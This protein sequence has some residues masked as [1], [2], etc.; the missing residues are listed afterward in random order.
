MLQ[1][2][3]QLMRVML[4]Y[5]EVRKS[6]QKL[7]YCVWFIQGFRLLAFRFSCFYPLCN[8]ISD[9]TL[10]LSE[11]GRLVLC[12]GVEVNTVT[13]ISAVDVANLHLGLL[14]W[15]LDHTHTSPLPWVFTRICEENIFTLYVEAP[16]V[17]VCNFC[18]VLR[19]FFAKNTLAVVGPEW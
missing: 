19:K 9:F 2:A 5:Y 15:I 10:N 8:G 6:L 3:S 13:T 12:W 18:V 1:T 4:I 7:Q 14:F 11:S 16:V 17:L